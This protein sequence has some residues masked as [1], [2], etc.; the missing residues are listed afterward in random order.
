MQI[1]LSVKSC[2][3]RR[4]RNPLIPHVNIIGFRKK[5]STHKENDNIKCRTGAEA[6]THPLIVSRLRLDDND[7]NFK[8][9]KPMRSRNLI[10]RAFINSQD[11]FSYIYASSQKFLFTWIGPIFKFLPRH[12]A[13]VNRAKPFD[14]TPLCF[15]RKIPRESIRTK[16]CSDPR[17]SFSTHFQTNRHII[18]KPH[19][20]HPQKNSQYEKKKKMRMR[21]SSAP[22]RSR[23]YIHSSLFCTIYIPFNG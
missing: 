20:A 4:M 17:R 7:V 14:P 12:G 5:W 13:D 9:Q 2:K 1:F 22:P 10:P 8:Y 21:V 18:K 23:A 16:N 6:V 11:Y 19:Y 15:I 3:S